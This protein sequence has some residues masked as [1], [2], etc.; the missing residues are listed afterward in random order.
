MRLAFRESQT[1][2]GGIINGGMLGTPPWDPEAGGGVGAVANHMRAQRRRRRP[3][4][5]RTLNDVAIAALRAYN[6]PSISVDRE[7]NGSLCEGPDGSLTHSVPNVGSV[8]ASSPS[9]CATGTT[10]VG[11]YH[12]HG[13]NNAL[14]DS[15][16]FS[17]QDRINSNN[18][19]LAAGRAVPNFIGTPSG[20]IRRFDPA[21]ISN[22]TRGRVT[23]FKTKIRTAPF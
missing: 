15:E 5:Y 11:T 1:A 21:A 18:R 16:N 9:P 20:T 6:V 8:S 14:Y 4:L 2:I 7:L 12:T 3:G 22:S 23:T 17:P 10:R 13:A 19:S